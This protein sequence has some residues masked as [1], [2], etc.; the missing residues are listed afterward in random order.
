MSRNPP[1]REATSVKAQRR[2]LSALLSWL[3]SD[4]Q[5][6]ARSLARAPGFALLAVIVLGLGLAAA[7]LVFALLNTVLWRPLPWAHA[8]EL[9]QVMVRRGPTG[10]EYSST[11]VERSIVEQWRARAADGVRLVASNEQ[12]HET[13]FYLTG[14]A[15]PERVL[16]AFV[17]PDFFDVL[18]THA[19]RGRGF[20][21]ADGAQVAVIA[22]RLWVRAFGSDRNVIGRTVN[23]NGT[24]CTI[25]GVMAE[26]FLPLPPLLRVEVDER[27]NVWVPLPGGVA[28][29]AGYDRVIVRVPA[30]VARPA[31]EAS[32]FQLARTVAGGDRVSGIELASL[33]DL[34]VGAARP[35]MAI[36]ALAAVLTVLLACTSIS[37]VQMARFTARRA[38]ASVRSALGASRGRVFVHLAAEGI[39]LAVAGAAGGLLLALWGLGLLRAIAPA[40]LPRLDQLRLGGGAIGFTLAL[41]AVAGLGTTIVPAALVARDARAV[42][43]RSTG[44]TAAPG[45]Q[46]TREALVVLQIMLALALLAGTGLLLRSMERLQRMEAGVQQAGVTV[47]DVPRRREGN[48]PA[49]APSFY[50][51]LVRRVRALPGVTHATLASSVPFR[52]RDYYAPD[53]RQRLIDR[54]YF[55]TLGIPVLDGRDFDERDEGASDR[56][57]VINQALADRL[58]ASVDPVGRRVDDV[59]VVGVVADVHHESLEEAAQPALYLPLAQQP[60]DRLSLLVRSAL[61]AAQLITAVRGEVAALDAD[62]PIAGVRSLSEIVERS[63]AVSRRRFP[64]RVLVMMAAFAALLAT[65]GVYGIAAHSVVQRTAEFGIRASLGATRRDLMAIVLRGALRMAGLGVIGG[66]ILALA[67][68]RS[69][70][71]VLFQVDAV[72]PGALGAAAAL[73]VA[74][75][76]CACL[77]PARRAATIDPALALRRE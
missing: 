69:L 51:E 1:G 25:V 37:A 64:L 58:F 74:A 6:A 70:R 9:Y 77:L 61:P 8:D 56:V 46:R 13:V 16:G 66:G 42:V 59:T 75:T 72:D 47:I 36:V 40:G 76:L 21:S 54:D 52:P 50:A 15:Q 23:V 26:D 7:A 53:Y 65:L 41:A 20:G 30:G 11:Q 57:A 29:G 34:L 33:R 68:G 35:G 48:R 27:A 62:Q 44:I 3:R 24:P 45:L 28:D 55:G 31:V 2:G 18:G 4:V 38:E 49:D 73:L 12:R 60:D 10:R 17:S 19:L 71:S 32:L 14:T 63:S 39:V 22:Y 43:T 5:L 67:F